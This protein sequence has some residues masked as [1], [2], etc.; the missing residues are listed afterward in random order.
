MSNVRKI[1]RK[2]AAAAAAGE[3]PLRRLYCGCGWQLPMMIG[4]KFHDP[5]KASAFVM[6]VVCPLCERV[7]PTGGGETEASPPQ[8]DRIRCKAFI[9]DNYRFA[10]STI[11]A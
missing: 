2:Q 4:V 6:G 11:A 3:A 8:E 9:I 5:S 10:L 7:H 1:Q